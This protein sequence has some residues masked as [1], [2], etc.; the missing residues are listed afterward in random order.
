MPTEKKS[1]VERTRRLSGKV[2]PF[3]LS[4]EDD[5]LRERAAS[6]KDGRAAKTLVK[7][8]PLS[9]VLVALRKGAAFKSHQVT[10]PVTIQSLRG[11][12]SVK[13]DTREIEVPAGTL[14][15]LGAG[16]THDARAQDDCAILLTVVLA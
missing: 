12:V 5:T 3:I 11:C 6:S 1:M 10:G 15:S 9:I 4:A 8:G 7:Q 14:V 2:L 16:V 13:T